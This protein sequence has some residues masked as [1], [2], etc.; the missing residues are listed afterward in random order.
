MP[1]FDRIYQGLFAGWVGHVLTLA[2]ALIELDELGYP[3]LSRRGH[4][5]HRLLATQAGML[6]HYHAQG[7]TPTLPAKASPLQA[8]FWNGDFAANN[9][10]YAHTFKYPLA[11]Y[12]MRPCLADDAERARIDA[13]MLHLWN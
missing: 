5:P 10:A 11:Y 3:E 7:L 1:K 8:E 9:W 4:R 2:H 13:V 6:H 12:A